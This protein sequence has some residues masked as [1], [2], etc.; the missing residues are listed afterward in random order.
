MF[1][2]I[3]DFKSAIA[4]ENILTPYKR[5]RL[6]QD[7]KSY[8]PKEPITP[9]VCMVVLKS[10]NNPRNIKDMLNCIAE[11]PQSEQAQ[12]KDIVLATF[13][14]RQQPEDIIEFGRAL[15][16]KGNFAL[17]LAKIIDMQQSYRIFSH[18]DKADKLKLL[19]MDEVRENPDLSVYTGVRIIGKRV[20]LRENIDFPRFLD[21]SEVDEATLSYNDLSAVEQIFLKK[22]GKFEVNMVDGVPKS[23]DVFEAN[24]VKIKNTDLKNSQ[25][26]VFAQGAKVEMNNARHIPPL[27]SFYNCAD[28]SIKDS[29]LS[30]LDELR[31][32]HDAQVLLNDISQMPRHIDV[33]K[34]KMLSFINVNFSGIDKLQFRTGAKVHFSNVSEIPPHSH[35]ENLTSLFFFA[36][37]C[38]KCTDFNF[39]NIEELSLSTIFA[40]PEHTRVVRPKK[41]SVLNSKLPQ[42]AVFDLVGTNIDFF[43]V[44]QFPSQ[45]DVSKS[46]QVTMDECH[47]AQF[48]KLTFM[49]GASVMLRAAKNLPKQAN[50]E[51]CRFL[52]LEKCDLSPYEEIRFR[53]GAA[54][55]LDYAHNLPKMMNFAHCGSVNFEQCDMSGVK[56]VFFWDEAQMLRFGFSK[57]LHW[58]GEVIFVGGR[59]KNLPCEMEPSSQ[60]SYS[61]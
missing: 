41:L 59:N 10:T 9:D 7:K 4:V 26:L 33:S 12:F 18:R 5:G 40:F 21:L 48:D 44:F 53:N 11:L 20:D 31:F 15:A 17:P 45:F 35:Y 57:A 19:T 47:L 42:N 28:V 36:T 1:V 8:L 29:N 14:E 27:S 23:F 61:R 50:F 49:E 39:Q 22:G 34:C 60:R 3:T 54:V 52:S 43:R 2:D 30:E 24:D 56:K 55:S 58:G 38:S 51:N 6:A 16:D 32:N 46:P 37:D 13:D 25:P